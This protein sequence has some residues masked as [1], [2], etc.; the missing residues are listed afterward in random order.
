MW[1]WFDG[2][3]LRKPLLWFIFTAI[4]NAGLLYFTQTFFQRQQIDYQQQYSKQQFMR[5][6]YSSKYSVQQFVQQAYPQFKQLK[7]QH[8]FQPQSD[9]LAYLD[10]LNRLQRQL[11]L[12]HFS[13]QLIKAQPHL[14]PENPLDTPVVLL[15][16]TVVELDLGLLHE[17]EL[18]QFLSAL[19]T[20]YAHRLQIQ[21][22]Q[23]KRQP[24]DGKQIQSVN[25]M[26]HCRL[27]FY[28]MVRI[29]DISD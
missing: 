16:R 14:L 23:L 15:Y 4:F 18:Y 25:V 27:H 22:C 9:G 5:E 8:Y 28:Y 10:S 7:D 24:S 13:Y 2:V 6:Q 1:A 12:A 11:H 3:F 19:A 17:G 20:E 21:S 29:D 26:A